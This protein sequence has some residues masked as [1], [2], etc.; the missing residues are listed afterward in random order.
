M[1]CNGVWVSFVAIRNTDDLARHREAVAAVSAYLPNVL[2]GELA[3]FRANFETLH[4]VLVN[5]VPVGLVS[6]DLYRHSA[7]LHGIL[8]PDFGELFYQAKHIKRVLY[9]HIFNWVFYTFDKQKIMMKGPPEDRRMKG[10]AWMFG[11]RRLATLDHGKAVWV[12]KRKDYER[13]G[14]KRNGDWTEKNKRGETDH[15]HVAI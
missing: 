3:D 4:L 13:R 14:T 7:E 8:R 6:A 2:A 1:G 11:F 10:F 12:L 5:Q 15:E 9:Q